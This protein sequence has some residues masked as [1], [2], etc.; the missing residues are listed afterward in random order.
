VALVRG[1]VGRSGKSI[2]NFWQD[3]VRTI[4]YVLGPLSVLIAIVLAS[5]GVIANSPTI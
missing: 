3:M 5:Q 1:I 2:G 4:L